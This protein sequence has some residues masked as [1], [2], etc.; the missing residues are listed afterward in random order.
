MTKLRILFALVV[1][2]AASSSATGLPG[3]SQSTNGKE[4]GSPLGD[5]DGNEETTATV[6]RAIANQLESGYVFPEL[7]ATMATQLRGSLAAGEY[8]DPLDGESLA[9]RLTA[10]L[11]RISKDKHLAVEYSHER[12]ADDAQVANDQYDAE[13]QQRYYG[14]HLNFGFEKVERVEPNVGVLDLRVFAPVE[15]GYDTATAAM[16]FLAHTDALIVDLRQN[17][18]GHGEMGHLLMAYFFDGGP[19]PVSGI[20]SRETNEI[21]RFHT[22]ARV[23]GPRYGS[24][25]PV[26]VLISERT[27]SAAEA[28][29]YDLQALGRVTVVG[30]PSGGGAHPFEYRRVSPHYVLLMV[31]ERSINPITESNWQGVG[32][33]P[34]IRVPADVAFQRALQLAKERLGPL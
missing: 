7:G 13:E 2:C 1:A 29:A 27:F 10:D 20:Y 23:S 17:A 31:T 16:Q 26:Y 25:K 30:E 14:N 12:L 34:D 5:L 6:V 19:K 9:Q 22:P 11:Q 28:F 3:Q 18:G 4:I 15:M 21:T 24:E 32:V 33:A 8:A